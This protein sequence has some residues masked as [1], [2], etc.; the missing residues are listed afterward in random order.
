MKFVAAALALAVAIALGAGISLAL[1]IVFAAIVS[2][3]VVWAWARAVEGPRAA[4]DRLVTHVVTSAFIL[5]VIPLVSL[6]ITVVGK[7][8]TISR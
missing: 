1:L 7:G 2:G 5:A 3:A 8:I 6:L 4:T